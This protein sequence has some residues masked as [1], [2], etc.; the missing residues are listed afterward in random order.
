MCIIWGLNS[1]FPTRYKACPLSVSSWLQNLSCSLPGSGINS[2][3]GLLYSWAVF[4]SGDLSFGSMDNIKQIKGPA[5]PLPTLNNGV[6]PYNQLSAPTPGSRPTGHPSP[7]QVLKLN[8]LDSQELRGRS[9]IGHSG[10]PAPEHSLA[11]RSV[12]NLYPENL[13]PPFPRG[14]VGRY[15]A[16]LDLP[17]SLSLPSAGVFL[18]F[19]C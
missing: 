17:A 3:N 9:R 6:P 18:Y 13:A 10:V 19:V 2:N 16:R 7:P 4:F 11:V 8:N 1:G 14:P 5:Y 12:R 15:G